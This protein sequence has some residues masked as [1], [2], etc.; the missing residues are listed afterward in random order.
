MEIHYRALGIAHL[1]YAILILI[2][3][4]LVFSILSGI[5]FLAEDPEVIAILSTIGFFVSMFL[6]LLAIPGLIAGFGCIQQK[7][8]GLALALVMGVLNILCFPFGTALGGY[9]I[10]V[11]VQVQEEKKK[12]TEHPSE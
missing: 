9:S 5:G 1:I 4:L 10:W 3:A 12:V 2:P 7:S 6:I 8:W 11:F